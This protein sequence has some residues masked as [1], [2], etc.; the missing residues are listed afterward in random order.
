MKRYIFFLFF[1]F[2]FSFPGFVFS[3]SI[4]IE[5][6]TPVELTDVHVGLSKNSEIILSTQSKDVKRN[7]EFKFNINKVYKDFQ[8]K[9]GF[10][11]FMYYVEFE[12]YG[13]KYSF[14]FGYGPAD[15]YIRLTIG[16]GNILSESDTGYKE[17]GENDLV[18]I[19]D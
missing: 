9:Y 19:L 14:I 16:M 5:N 7:G 6:R 15:N 3:Q 12:Y 11:E 8:K 18:F 10:A 13:K 17:Y 1:L 4:L 2:L